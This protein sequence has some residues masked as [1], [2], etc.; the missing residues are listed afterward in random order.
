MKTRFI[1]NALCSGR[2]GSGQSEESVAIVRKAFDL[3]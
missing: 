1:I 3:S 2:L